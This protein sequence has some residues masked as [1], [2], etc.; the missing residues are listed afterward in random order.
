MEVED[1]EG[2]VVGVL[3]ASGAGSSVIEASGL[4]HRG[5]ILD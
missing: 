1:V 4:G 2:E 5:S 3:A